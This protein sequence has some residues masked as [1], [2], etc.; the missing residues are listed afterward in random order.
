[1][2][3]NLECIFMFPT[4]DAH[5]SARNA[6]QNVVD[7]KYSYAWFFIAGYAV[8]KVARLGSWPRQRARLKVGAEPRM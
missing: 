4:A 5:F 7:H 3:L 6:A 1:M 2:F 8:L